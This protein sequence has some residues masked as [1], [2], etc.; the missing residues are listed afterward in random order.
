MTNIWISV[1]RTSIDTRDD[2]FTG[3]PTPI[4]QCYF[5]DKGFGEVNIVPSIAYGSVPTFIRASTAWTRLNTGLWAQVA[6]NIPRSYYGVVYGQPFTGYYNGYL[7][8]LGNTNV[9][10]WSRDITNPAWLK[11]TLNTVKNQTGIDG[12]T[13]SATKITA[14]AAFGTTTQILGSNSGTFSLFAKRITGVGELW[15]TRDAGVNW[16]NVSPTLDLVPYGEWST[17]PLFTT[18]GGVSNVVGI[19]VVTN[20][21][22]FGID[23]CQSEDSSF[24]S[25]TTPIPTTNVP[26]ARAS[27]DL[28]FTTTNIFNLQDFTVLST[29]IPTFDI[30]NNVLFPLLSKLDANNLIVLF[31]FTSGSFAR[32]V[33]GISTQASE[34][35]GIPSV[36]VPLNIAGINSSKFGI[37]EIRKNQVATS[38]VSQSVKSAVVG[39]SMSIG[40]DLNGLVWG[41]FATRKLNIYNIALDA[42]QLEQVPV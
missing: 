41:S 13:N 6:N 21:D 15:I 34:N 35:I 27:D 37:N 8:E 16:L 10:L 19:R 14:A 7:H 12:V 17:G 5:S 30:S 18:L 23:M 26:V 39:T 36:G 24:N 33:G 22:E 38:F 1:P 42:Y 32:V 3:Q 29:I 28:S 11:V 20:S 40:K 4:F 2:P 31:S 25:I 9:C